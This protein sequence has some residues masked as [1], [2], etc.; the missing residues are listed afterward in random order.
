MDLKLLRVFGSDES[1]LSMLFVNTTPE[2]FI[3]EDEKRDIKIKGETRIPAGKYP[4]I[5]REVVSPMTE[6]YR[7]K[8]TWF[9]YHLMLVDVPN[10]SNIYIHP[11]V[12]EEHTDG[13]LL[14]GDVLYSNQCKIDKYENGAVMYSSQ[15]FERLYKK[16]QPLL[17]KK[18]EEVWI[19]IE[20]YTP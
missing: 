7:K 17:A 13:C 9:T 12:T 20:D 2:C 14:T 8:F 11:G 18:Q 15:A 19:E 1:T 5:L 16:I 4:I 6:K 10:F 3:L